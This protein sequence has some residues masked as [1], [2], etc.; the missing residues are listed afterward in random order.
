MEARRQGAGAL[1]PWASA[2][3][4]HARCRAFD[5]L[6][7]QRPGRTDRA[8]RPRF[9]K[10]EYWRQFSAPAPPCATFCNLQARLSGFVQASRRVH[11]ISPAQSLAQTGSPPMCRTNLAPSCS[12]WRSNAVPGIARPIRHAGSRV[13][14]G[15]AVPISQ[16]PRDYFLPGFVDVL[17]F[18]LSVIDLEPC[19]RPGRKEFIVL[20][21]HAPIG[22]HAFPAPV[23]LRTVRR[24]QLVRP[25]IV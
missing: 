15:V 20:K 13:M 24:F 10:K 7:P 2:P 19:T 8:R 11:A 9:Q 16:K 17:D 23:P 1:S 21:E 14:L 6:F 4:G 5:R 3:S 18:Q 12:T 22:D 25:P